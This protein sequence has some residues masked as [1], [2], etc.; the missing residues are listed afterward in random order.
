[1]IKKIFLVL[2]LFT[3]I[4]LNSCDQCIGNAGD[5]LQL[6]G[7]I[8]FKINNSISFAEKDTLII[9]KKWTEQIKDSLSYKWIQFYKYDTLILNTN[10]DYEQKLNGKIYPASML[11]T[12]QNSENNE[13]VNDTAWLTFGKYHYEILGIQNTVKRS[14]KCNDNLTT[15][16]KNIHLNGIKANLLKNETY[17]NIFKIENQTITF[18]P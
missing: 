15:L 4:L 13:N 5:E 6:Y 12:L 3:A 10:N 18:L 17:S 14:G 1:M 7:G 2:I 11:I 8:E 16:E 9:K